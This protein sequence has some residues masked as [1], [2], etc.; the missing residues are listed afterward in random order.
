VWQVEKK[1]DGTF[2]RKA[3]LDFFD[4]YKKSAAK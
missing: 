4:A 2:G 1:A 3:A